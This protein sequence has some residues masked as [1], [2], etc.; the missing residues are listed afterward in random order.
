MEKIEPAATIE[1]GQY[2]RIER[3]MGNGSV[4][5]ELRQAPETIVQQS[6]IGERTAEVRRFILGTLATSSKQED[7]EAGWRQIQQSARYEKL[8]ELKEV[9]GDILS[10]DLKEL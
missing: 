1:T 9:P 8:K 6:H 4:V 10:I 5:L 2:I 3:K 7:L